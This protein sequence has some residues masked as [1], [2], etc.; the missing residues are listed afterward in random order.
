M[1]IIIDNQIVKKKEKSASSV[2]LSKFNTSFREMLITA[3]IGAAVV[4]GASYGSINS[5][6]ARVCLPGEYNDK[7]NCVSC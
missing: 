7:A 4:L 6:A 5:Y 2:A 3:I 1:E